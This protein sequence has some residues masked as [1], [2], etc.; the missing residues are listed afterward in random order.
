M[1]SLAKTKRPWEEV[2]ALKR[3]A[4]LDALRE[5]GHDDHEPLQDIHV[6]IKAS[7]VINSLTSGAVTCEDLV[8]SHIQKSVLV[9]IS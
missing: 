8:K 7:H 6:S 4:Q 2:V 1:A 5:F 3:Q 9:G